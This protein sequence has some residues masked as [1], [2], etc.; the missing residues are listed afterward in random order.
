M[1]ETLNKPYFSSSFLRLPAEKDA[2][3]EIG[4]QYTLIVR[5]SFLFE[6]LKLST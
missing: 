4:N 2:V 1:T 5:P 6:F 3:H